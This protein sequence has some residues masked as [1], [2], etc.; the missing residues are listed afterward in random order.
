[1]ETVSSQLERLN[2]IVVSLFVFCIT[3]MFYLFISIVWMH[4]KDFF[5]ELK[6]RSNFATSRSYEKKWKKKNV[7]TLEELEREVSDKKTEVEG[8]LCNI[9]DLSRSIEKLTEKRDNVTRE[10]AAE[11][12]RRLRL[13]KEIAENQPRMIA[14][15]LRYLMVGDMFDG[16]AMEHK[17]AAWKLMEDILTDKLGRDIRDGVF[18]ELFENGIPPECW[19]REAVRV[20]V[21]KLNAF[22]R[23]LGYDVVENREKKYTSKDLFDSVQEAIA[24]REKE[25]E[26][27]ISE[28]NSIMPVMAL[29]IR[30]YPS[31]SLVEAMREMERVM[32]K[33]VLTNR[34]YKIE[35]VDRD[36][37]LSRLGKLAREIN[38]YNAPTPREQKNA[39]ES[40]NVG[41]E[42]TTSEESGTE[43]GEEESTED[44]NVDVEETT[45]TYCEREGK[46]KG[47]QFSYGDKVVPITKTRGTPLD[48]CT[49]WKRN[50]KRGYLYVVGYVNHSDTL[51]LSESKDWWLKIRRVCFAPSDVELFPKVQ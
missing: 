13:R 44:K 38:G 45:S 50:K 19:N 17:Q 29:E 34:P 36:S 4:V 35:H 18:A 14:D 11:E 16:I 12:A 26:K 5:M 49:V 1:M 3:V 7:K 48:A 25:F 8:L 30:D 6:L 42:E 2:W 22:G 37:R 10:V 23:A 39:P 31:T 15:G 40:E 32:S 51:L 20:S 46:I 41:T 33:V 9:T 27:C 28:L 43:E 24:E 47:T 21:D